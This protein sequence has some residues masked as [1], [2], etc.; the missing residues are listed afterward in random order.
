[1]SCVNPNSPEFKKILEQEPNFLLAEIMYD[2]L[3]QEQ[4]YKMYDDTLEFKE[5]TPIT[6]EQELI[7]QTEDWGFK[8]PSE[9]ALISDKELSLLM[10]NPA[11]NKIEDPVD[12][13][14]FN[15]LANAIGEKEAWRD[16]FETNKIVRPAN[17]VLEKLF[18]RLEDEEQNFQDTVNESMDLQLPSIDEFINQF[19]QVVEVE[20]KARALDVAEKLSKQL[21]VPYEVITQKELEEKFPNQSYRKAFYQAGKVYIVAGNLTAS[22]VFHEFAHPIVKSMSKQNPELFQKLFDELAATELGQRIIADLNLDPDLTPGTAAYMEEAIVT[23]LEAI[24]ENEEVAPKS[25]IQNLFFQIKQFLRKVFGKKIDVSKLNSKT[26]LADLVKMINYGEEFILDTEFLDKDLMVMFKTDYELL[27]Q[28]IKDGSAKKT[29]ELMNKFHD[30]VKLQLSNF[31]AENDIFKTIEVGLADENRE[32]LLNQAQMILEGL[33]TFG[34][35]NI[36]IPLDALNITGN[37][38]I[39]ADI[40]SFNNKIN[41]FVQVISTVDEVVDLLNNKLKA[42]AASG[43]KEN[44]EFDQLFAIMQYNEE[45]L[46]KITDWKSE[47]TTY[48]LV[49]DPSTGQQVNP[50]YDAL[51]E[52]QEKLNAGKIISDRLQMDSVIDVLY[53]HLNELMTPIKKDYLDQM[54][55]LKKLG[56]MAAYNKLHAEYY[57]LTPTDMVEYNRL[58]NKPEASLTRDE[59]IQLQELKFATFNSHVISKDALRAKAEGRLGDSHK[60]NGL[61]ESFMNNQ[62]QI[63]GGFYSFLMKT[64]NTIDGNANARR[65]ELLNNLQ[66]LLKAAGYDTH[67]LGEG[68]LGKEVGQ[69]N[70]SFKTNNKGQSE[71]FLEWQFLSNFHNYEYDRQLLLD[72]VKFARQKFNLN[73]DAK[74]RDPLKAEFEKAKEAL[75]DFD[76]KYMN[77]DYTDEFYQVAARYFK[78]DSGKLAKAAL[79]DL[80]DR[81]RVISEN[82]DVNPT[83]FGKVDALNELWNEYQLLHNIYDFKTGEEKTGISREIAEILTGYRNEISEFYEWEEKENAFEL[84]LELLHDELVSKG[85]HPGSDAYNAVMEEW[86]KHNTTIAVNE[87]YYINRAAL[88]EERSFLVEPITRIN[89]SF[90][91]VTPMYEQIYGILKP[92]KDNFNQY[93]GNDLTPTAQAKI[94]DIQQTISNLKEQWLNIKGYSPQEMRNFRRIEE[95]YLE[96]GEFEYDNDQDFYNNFWIDLQKRLANLGIDK[97]T[98][99]RVREID[100]ELNGSKLSGLTQPYISNLKAFV[101][102]NDAFANIFEDAFKAYDFVDGEFPTSQDI[103]EAIKDTKFTDALSAT[104]PEFKE[105]FDRNHYTESVNE[106]DKVDGHFVGEFTRNRPTAAW[107]FTMPSEI[108]DYETKSVLGTKIPAEF[109]PNGYIELNGVPRIPTRAYY[110][111]KVKQEFETAKIERDYVDNNGDLV[112][113]TVDNRGN[114][115]PKNLD[116]TDPN[117]KYVNGAYKK[118]FS[119]QKNLWNLLDYLKNKHLDNQKGLD[120]SQKMYLSYPRYRKGDVEEYDKNYF[121][122]KWNRVAETWRGAE[123]DF[124]YGIRTNDQ[125]TASYKTLTRPIGGSYKLDISDVSTN[126]IDKMLDHSYSIEHFKGMRK[127]NSFANVFENAM[128]N[129]YTNPAKTVVDKMLKDSELLEK[130]DSAQ[131]RRIKNIREIIDKNFKGVTIT[132]FVSGGTDASG[133]TM[134]TARV[135]GGL[136]RWMSFTSFALDPVKSVRNY[137]GGKSM[138]YKKATEGSVY[139]MKDVALTRGKSASVMGEL[140]AMQ[141][142]NKNVSARLQLL[143]ILNAIPGNLKKEI[144]ARGSKT[145]SQSLFGGSFFYADRKYLS[146]SVPVHQFLAILEHNSIMLNGKKTSLDEAIELID[147]KIQTV[148]GVPADMAITYDADGNIKFGKKIQDLMNE[149]QSFLQKSLGIAN[150][151]NEP[152]VYRSLLGKAAFFLMKFFPGM[153]L[154]RYQIR[155]KKGKRGQRRLNYSTRRAEL[156]TYLGIVAL[157]NELVSNK[158]KFWQL[159]AYS[160]QAKKGAM[161]LVLAKMISMIINMLAMS[162]GFDDDDDGLIDF[163]W[164]PNDDGIYSKLKHSTSLPELPLISDARTIK[165]TNK[166][167]HS[168]NYLKLQTLRLLLVF[169]KEED[170]F[171]LTNALSTTKDIVTGQSPLFTGGGLATIE[172]LASSLYATYFT[173]KPDVYEKAAGPYTFQEADKNKALN[174]VLKSMGLSGSLVDGATTIQR[175]NSD[176]FN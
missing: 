60:W 28:Q 3:M 63:V 100:K 150:E 27:K 78:T 10:N 93:N 136:Q 12:Q 132:G 32:G 155:T 54:D 49:T 112:I 125:Q 55:S 87:N 31:K 82:A 146:E 64:F 86:I 47:Y 17:V 129:M 13:Q 118:M 44:N 14:K 73:K 138:M 160:W 107:Q 9:V 102:T 113:A 168:E 23:A 26:T 50:I 77:R 148:A 5:S 153:A 151:F 46:A 115:L 74:S 128:T 88:I 172:D 164:D 11:Y 51:D 40:I 42:L 156:G 92:S 130:Q 171:F 147:G 90:I 34:S 116:E 175:E 43:V 80:F 8:N 170:T 167:F 157:A 65:G 68:K 135:I 84:A 35:R 69:I 134:F 121:Q 75:E 137:V 89:N 166:R 58:K 72:A 94:K 152:E 109:S 144:G 71:E 19:E 124:E 104:S 56:S 106:F 119:N 158:G 133:G 143:D 61:F 101:E 122:R 2:K 131:S 149:H 123:D 21:N 24:N 45:W 62:D 111:R 70:R 120:A 18:K 139:N 1:M 83:N 105:W 114:W 81:M 79:D 15:E 7:G 41:S 4:T 108:S 127:V 110:R 154:D 67:F 38:A 103:F 76:I 66:P 95:Y 52:L 173:D 117:A 145:V 99:D 36:V 20:N 53:D 37:T 163:T 39:D 162:I 22:D 30:V 142:S 48:S 161:Q 85:K 176:F 96:N 97:D 165:G 57:G 25:F 6:K 98:L 91:D 169:K 29:Q 159:N 174:I 140:I 33:A 59:M 126:I 141:Y 16:Y